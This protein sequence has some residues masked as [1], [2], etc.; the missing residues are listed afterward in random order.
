[1]KSLSFKDENG[2]FYYGWWIV[3][4]AA[5]VTGLVYSAI[6]T[7]TGVFM[8]PVTEDLGLSVAA[9]SL[10]L[11]VMSVT[12]IVTLAII[13][14]FLN[15]K[16][17]K[18]IMIIAGIIGVISFIGFAAAKNVWMFYIFAVPQGFC[19]A[20]MT[21]TP[22]Q[23]LV[24]NW[25]G[26]KAKGRAIS[27]F[28]T[29]MT[30]VYLL[31][32]NILSKVVVSMGWRAGYVML[33]ACVAIGV[34]V[35]AALVSWSPEKKGIRRIG[36]LDES[37][38]QAMQ[39]SVLKGIDFKVAIR[40]PITWLVLISCTLAVIASSSILQHG[41]PT[42]V[43]SGSTPEQATGIISVLSLVMLFTGPV[44]GVICDKCRLTVAAVGTAASFAIAALGLSMMGTSQAGMW[45]FCVFYI[46]GVPTIN[47]I[48]PLLMNYMYGE[49]DM[50]RLIGYVNMFIAIGGAIGAAGLG[51]LYEHYGS[52]QTPWLI[53][54]AVLALVAVVRA[55]ATT[56][57]R[58]YNPEMDM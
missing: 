29:G 26:E 58:K 57:K 16:H 13:S 24:S 52:Y 6:V 3:I 4:A 51:A 33:A 19:F 40:K 49:K 21:M 10:Y 47:I 41:I 18:K 11:T 15:E 14:K 20:A 17:I 46:L 50:P 35:A 1:M 44:I 32:F 27:L 56:K 22:C 55:V 8:L 23:L 31:E 30:L 43:I 38:L 12:G 25:F 39:S 48:S 9:Y 2:K 7:V 28:L 42:M 34:I 5:I 54:A 37:E 53:I 45:I 36:D